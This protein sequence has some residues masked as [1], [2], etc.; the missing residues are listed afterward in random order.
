MR[1]E[2]FQRGLK[3]LFLGFFVRIY[4]GGIVPSGNKVDGH[5]KR[6]E[7]AEYLSAYTTGRYG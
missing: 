2:S 5:G 7:L 6:T 3:N 4:L 1:Q